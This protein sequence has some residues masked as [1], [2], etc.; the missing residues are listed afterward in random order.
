MTKSNL[1]RFA[2]RVLHKNDNSQPGSSLRNPMAP[3]EE[4]CA[5]FKSAPENIHLEIPRP[6]SSLETKA[7]NVLSPRQ[8]RHARRKLA[9]ARRWNNEVLPSLIQPFMEYERNTHS[10]SAPLPFA[11]GVNHFLCK[12]L[13]RQQLLIL[14]V[15]FDRKSGINQGAYLY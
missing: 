14:C 11:N 4:S 13:R 10:G 7:P 8:S 6:L 9:A 1:T 12:C 5:Q 2:H 3:F 15:Y